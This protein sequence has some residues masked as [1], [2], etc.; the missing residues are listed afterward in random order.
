MRQPA[1]RA[2]LSDDSPFRLTSFQADEP[3]A[4]AEN[5]A[6]VDEPPTATNEGQPAEA[7]PAGTN[8]GQ[9]ATAEAEPAAGTRV[10]QARPSLAGQST[11]LLTFGQGMSAESVRSLISSAVTE[12]FGE[13]DLPPIVL[14]NP[15]WDGLS[16][17][18][19]RKWEVQLALS[20]AATDKVLHAMQDD[21]KDM[22]VWLQ[23]NKIGSQVA[24]NMQ[25][26]AIGALL[27]SLLG[28]IGYIWFR[29]QRVVFGLAAVVALVHDVLI[30][31]GAIASSLWLSHVFGF[32]LLDEFKISLPIVAALLTLIG[33][34]LNDTIVVFD[35]IREV[36]GKNPDMT[37]EMI[38]TS[39]NQTLSRTLLTS[40]TTLIVVL[41]LY[42]LGGQA[43]RGFAFTLLIGIIVGTYS[44][45][46]IASPFLLW[47][48][49]AT[50]AK[51]R[52]TAKSKATT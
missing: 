44:S 30:T 37:A 20:E 31:L 45:I 14:R 10:P 13:I 4:Q 34:S 9:P 40:G 1:K 47:M 48:M 26:T 43:I 22:P 15:D 50:Q 51:K 38:N 21:L 28:I 41:V 17:Q 11:R 2:Q 8:E 12:E 42:F 36:R 49:N 25:R 27:G 19:F 3:A 6:A 18:R 23:S 46:F 35:R 52:Q 29:F 16:S 33:Y 24:G 5:P 7:E 39:I 32:L